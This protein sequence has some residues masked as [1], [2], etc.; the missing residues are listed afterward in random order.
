MGDVELYTGS[1]EGPR[2]TLETDAVV[3]SRTATEYTAA[4][5]TYGLVEGDLRA[6]L[7]MAAAGS[8]LGSARPAG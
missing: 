1:V 5:R 8:P 7:D 4:T 3:R 6:A 2:V